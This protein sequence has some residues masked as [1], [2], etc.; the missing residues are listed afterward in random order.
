MSRFL[1]A[2]SHFYKDT[3]E[4]IEHLDPPVEGYV[5]PSYKSSDLNTLIIKQNNTIIKLL[6]AIAQQ[7][8]D[9][10]TG[11]DAL[12]REL[13]ANT[14]Q[15]AR[16]KEISERLNKLSLVENPMPRKD[17]GPFFVLNDPT[18]ILE[19]PLKKVPQ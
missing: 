13:K 8:E 18:E 11:L 5:W 17:K 15:E 10:K 1:S 6:L 19:E 14:H 7:V 16:L 4:K 12:K 2:Q 9:Y 3:L